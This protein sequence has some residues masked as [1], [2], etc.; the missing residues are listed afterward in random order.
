MSEAGDP[1]FPHFNR[2]VADAI[3]AANNAATTG[4]HHYLGA[5]IR[6]ITPGRLRATVPVRD[7]LLTPFGTM[8][9]GVMAAL[10]DHILG[11]VLYPLMMPGQWAA[12][13]EFKLNYLA[14][15]KSGVLN[16]E[17]SVVSMSRRTAVVRAEVRNDERLACIAQGTLLNVDPKPRDHQHAAEVS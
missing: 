12:T 7:E 8:H 6:E 1:D 16:A 5:L 2:N 17:S 9:G 4:L 14:P 3:V 11:A 13:T 10:V 15:V